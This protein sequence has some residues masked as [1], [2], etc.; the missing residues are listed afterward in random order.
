MVLVLGMIT[1]SFLR[2]PRAS[3]LFSRLF[4][5]DRL[6]GNGLRELPRAPGDEIGS[7]GNDFVLSAHGVNGGADDAPAFTRH[8]RHDGERK[9]AVEGTALP[10][11]HHREVLF[12]RRDETR[13]ERA[14][15]GSRDEAQPVFGGA[16][17]QP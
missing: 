13:S 2:N 14:L 5:M 10:R 6:F 11:R 15:L 4:A 16:L 7:V 9:Q 12:E 1:A 3:L 8:P 17:E